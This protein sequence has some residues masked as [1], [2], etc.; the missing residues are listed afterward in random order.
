MTLFKIKVDLIRG[1]VLAESGFD[2]GVSFEGRTRVDIRSCF[3]NQG[4]R[5][6]LSGRLYSFHTQDELQGWLGRFHASRINTWIREVD[7]DLVIL[8]V[9]AKRHEAYLISDR[10]GPT[11]SYYHYKGGCLSISNSRRELISLLGSAKISSFPA[12]QLLTLGYVIDP[13][14]LL[15]QVAVT[16][17]GQI[18]RFFARRDPQ[19]YPYFPLVQSDCKYF[20]TDS[21]CV[22]A[23]DGAY[24]QLFSKRLGD[25]RVPCVMLSGG[26][27]SLTIMKYLKEAY[28]GKLHSLTYSFKGLHPNELEPARMAARHFGT[29]HHEVMIDPEDAGALFVQNLQ[30]DAAD[31]TYLTSFAIRPYLERLG[32]SFDLFTGQDT[33]LHTPPF[34][35]PIEIGIYLNRYPESTY[36]PRLLGS[37]ASHLLGHWPVDGPFKRYLRYWRSSL[38]PRGSFK[39]FVLDALTHF[40]TPGFNGGARGKFYQALLHELP[41][42]RAEDS[43]QQIFKKYV[44]FEY[45]AQYTDDMNC[46]ASTLTGPATEVHCPFYDWQAVEASNRVPYH[47]GM[48]GTFTFKTWNKMPYVRKRIARLLVQDAVPQNLLYRA[49]KTCPHFDLIFSSSMGSTTRQLL[50]RWLPALLESVDPE[51]REIIRAYVRVFS[52][53]ARFTLY[54]EPLLRRVQAI[55]F[56]ATLLQACQ[57]PSIRLDEELVSITQAA[58]RENQLSS[59]F[60]A[61]FG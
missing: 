27:D 55:C 22:T 42:L 57:K 61:A 6:Y 54:D 38:R 17:P 56:L 32:G 13:D 2:K 10:N 35:N 5:F 34:D 51:V 48:R 18:V 23:L 20:E 9:D 47:L 7:G 1:L 25:T 31:G 3:E 11:R 30:T 39:S 43:M 37:V 53:K 8:V 41:E 28:A 60:A 46:I 16:T 49:K 12:Y 40:N 15:E 29:E 58:A 21:E 4:C 45:R 33:R 52:S 50:Q 14:S 24:R 19:V 36:F 44:S 59:E 26:I